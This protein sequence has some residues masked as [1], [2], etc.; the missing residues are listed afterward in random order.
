LHYSTEY[1]VGATH[2]RDIIDDY[3]RRSD[4]EFNRVN[5]GCELD[6]AEQRRRWV[7]KSLLRTEGLD[8][9]AYLARFG[10]DVFSDLPELSELLEHGLA[11]MAER[12]V[13]TPEGLERSDAIG[14]W[15]HSPAVRERMAAYEPH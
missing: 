6:E 13:L 5:Y 4:S 1:A 12:L 15:L 8:R 2:V 3:C 9:H 10:T 14:P 7:I 11:E